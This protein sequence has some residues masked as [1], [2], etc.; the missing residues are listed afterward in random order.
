MNTTKSTLSDSEMKSVETV[1]EYLYEDEKRHYF[2][3]GMYNR[4]NHIFSYLLVLKSLLKSCKNEDS[5]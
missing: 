2:E 5:K 4:E 3:S 1:I